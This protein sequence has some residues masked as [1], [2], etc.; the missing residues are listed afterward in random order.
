M[1]SERLSIWLRKLLMVF[2][3]VNT[4]KVCPWLSPPQVICWVRTLLPV[5][6]APSMRFSEWTGRPSAIFL[7]ISVLPVDSTFFF[8][9]FSFNS[10]IAI[11]F[12]LKPL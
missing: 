4:A 1:S 10:T 8:F 2:S 5:S 11:A 6:F 3:V 7:S 9:S 12:T